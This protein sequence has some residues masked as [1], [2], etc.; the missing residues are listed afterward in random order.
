MQVKRAIG[1]GRLVSF[2][3]GKYRHPTWEK[4][5]LMFVDLNASTTIAPW[6]G[7]EARLG[8]NPLSIAAPCPQLTSP[9]TPHFLLDMAMSVAHRYASFGSG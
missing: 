9:G 8:N 5:I 4:N 1:K 3:T 7:R 6:G 2:V